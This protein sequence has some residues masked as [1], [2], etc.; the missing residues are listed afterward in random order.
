MY[1]TNIACK[2]AGVFHGN[3][4]VSMRPIPYALVP[5]AVQVTGSM[6]KVHGAPVHIG[7][8]K[9]I[10]IHDLAKPDFNDPGGRSTGVL[11]VRCDTAGCGHGIKTEL[12][13][14]A[15]AGAYACNGCQKY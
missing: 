14:Y 15:C 11:A 7:D 10:G 12:L 2:S 1:R 9:V 4:V 6:P 8:P 13:Y 3:M 5:K